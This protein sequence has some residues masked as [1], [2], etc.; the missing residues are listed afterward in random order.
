MIIL[1]L[2]VFLIGYTAI[3][4]ENKININ[5]AATALITGVI[6]W[7]IYVAWSPDKRVVEEQLTMHLGELSGILFFLLSAMTIVELIDA[8][9]GF[10]IITDRIN[11]TNQRRLIW[12]IAFI[13]FFLSAVDPATAGP[14]EGKKTPREGFL[15]YPRFRSLYRRKGENM[16]PSLSI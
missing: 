9:D 1:L 11:E 12:I 7:T 3:A 4:L 10:N 13:S 6:C 2:A 15:T 5:K 8:H 16:S 14:K